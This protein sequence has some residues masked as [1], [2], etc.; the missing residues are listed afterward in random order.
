MEE[1][2]AAD[3]PYLPYDGGGDTIPLQEIP[4]RGTPRFPC[5]PTP[6]PYQRPTFFFS[7]FFSEHVNPYGR[8]ISRFFWGV[9]TDGIFL[10]IATV[11]FNSLLIIDQLC[12]P[13]MTR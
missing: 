9:K 10:K 1:E 12:A 11:T 6:L 4:R 3:D 13:K 8:F 5:F 2:D 7:F